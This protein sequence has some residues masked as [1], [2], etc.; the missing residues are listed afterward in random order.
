MEVKPLYEDVKQKM[1]ER[2]VPDID[3]TTVNRLLHLVCKQNRQFGE[4][5]YKHVY[6]LIVFYA[7]EN[8]IEFDAS[9]PLFQGNLCTGGRGVRY[10]S[11]PL[12][13]E[14]EGIIKT[15][16]HYRTH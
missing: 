13:P 11:A 9:R 8:N 14:L 7:V 3:I 15:Y 16:V 1:E 4:E 10:T 5:M 6:A 12:P 2:G